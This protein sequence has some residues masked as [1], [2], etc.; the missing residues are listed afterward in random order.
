[1]EGQELPADGGKKKNKLCYP[2]FNTERLLALSSETTSSL[3]CPKTSIDLFNAFNSKLS[4]NF[5]TTQ[6]MN[7]TKVVISVA[8]FVPSFPNILCYRR[9]DIINKKQFIFYKISSR[10]MAAHPQGTF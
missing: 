4:Y 7:A 1:M 3:S 2:G 8:N 6:K 5:L 10:N 9:Y